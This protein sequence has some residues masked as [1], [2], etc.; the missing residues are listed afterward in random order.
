MKIIIDR[1]QDDFVVVELPNKSIMSIPKAIIP[2]D[3][4]EGDVLIVQVDRKG[5]KKK[6]QEIEKLIEDVWKK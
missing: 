4:K 1:F 2:E 3:A 5:T 6:K